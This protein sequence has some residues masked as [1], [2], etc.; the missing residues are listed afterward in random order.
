MLEQFK[1]ASFLW[2]GAQVLA[3]SI[4]YRSLVL[5]DS[6]Q[7]DGLGLWTGGERRDNKLKGVQEWKTP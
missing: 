5:C 7:R 3:V 2:A 1:K 4:V 6:L